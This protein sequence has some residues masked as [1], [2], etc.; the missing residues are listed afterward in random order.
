MELVQSNETISL[1]IF[2]FINN[3]Y[4]M[5]IVIMFT[6]LKLHLMLNAIQ[7]LMINLPQIPSNL[8]NVDQIAN[9]VS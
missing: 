3:S 4:V 1:E 8:T 7:I 9:F 5:H 6:S 2:H